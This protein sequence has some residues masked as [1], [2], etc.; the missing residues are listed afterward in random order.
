MPNPTDLALAPS[1]SDVATR[2]GAGLVTQIGGGR[3]MGIGSLPHRDADAAAAFSVGEFDIATVPTLPQRSP[4]EGMIAQ[5]VAGLPGVSLGQYGS[6]AVDP[7]HLGDDVPITTDL[8]GDA[9][10]GLRA[11]LDLAVAIGHDGK[12]V[13][14]Q[15]V[16]PVTLGVALQ[17]AGLRTSA[18]FTIAA[19]AVRQH[20]TD[21]GAAIRVALPSSPQIFVLDEPWLVDLMSPDFPIAPDE[22][23]DLISTA[24]AAA[25]DATF[26]VHC[27]GPADVATML[28][29]GPKL[30]SVAVDDGLVDYAGY[31]GR[32]LDDGGVVAWG[33]VPTDRP[34]GP[35]ADRY[36]RQL[37]ELWCALVERGVDATKLRRQSLITPT[38]G[39]AAHQVSV[40]RRLTR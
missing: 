26:G 23:V 24:M 13:K 14:W 28:S 32:F 39:F 6:F 3:L 5:A 36:W 2:A 40:A 31:L 37:A 25:S 16:G 17:R 38:C 27:C 7:S 10:G 15:F 19:R 30:L 1:S 34:A 33:V 8:D 11:F 4:A 22:A 35:S 20:V 18:A 9:F 29:S 12:P 21:I